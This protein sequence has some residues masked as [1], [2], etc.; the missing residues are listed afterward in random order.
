MRVKTPA[1]AAAERLA[2][3]LNPAQ[4]RTH[5]RP[6]PRDQGDHFDVN[7]LKTLRMVRA[8]KERGYS[9]EQAC[10]R[11]SMNRKSLAKYW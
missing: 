5:E 11:L 1:Q 3:N 8:V 2:L 7:G 10:Q 4:V 9:F 6:G